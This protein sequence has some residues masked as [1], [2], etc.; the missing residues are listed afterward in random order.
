MYFILFRFLARLPFWFLYAVSD[1]LFFLLA[2]LIRYRRKV[3]LHNL[4]LAFPDQTDAFYKTTTRRFYRNLADVI[5]ETIKLPGMSA[6]EL[7]RRVVFTNDELVKNRLG[8]GEVVV[9]MASHQCNWEWVPSASVLNGMPAD[10]IYKPLNNP[11]FEQLV[12]SIR[13]H[14]GAKP[15]PMQQLLRQMVSRRSEPRL[16]AL[17][18]DQ[19]P[20][21]P[22]YGYWT[23]FMHQDTPFYPGTE[24]LAKAQKLPVYY[25]EIRRIRRGHYQAT[26]HSVAEP[27]YDGLADGEIIDRYRDLLQK[28]IEQAPADWLWSHKRW[29]H[30]RAK[31]EGKIQVK[32]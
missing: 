13:G 2:Y 32:W 28:S 25:V 19:V 5:V 22:E 6:A 16:V 23:Q 4:R 31:Y 21:K 11:V 17:V 30:Q 14:F 18:A 24:R 1:L 10:A 27:P 29:K 20:D 12:S 9:I 15:V 26:F 8:K 7:R 3:I